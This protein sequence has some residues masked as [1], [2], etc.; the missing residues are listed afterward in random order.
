[1]NAENNKLR[2]QGALPNRDGLPTRVSL[3]LRQSTW[4]PTRMKVCM[5]LAP[6]EIPDG[7]FEPFVG[8]IRSGQ[9]IV[10][11]AEFRLEMN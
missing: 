9:M 6:D 5:A 4:S 8:D 7:V 11:L 10:V 3:N 2:M 1:V